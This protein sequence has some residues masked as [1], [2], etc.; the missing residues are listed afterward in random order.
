MARFLP[1][2]IAI[3]PTFAIPAICCLI[4]FVLLD[5]AIDHK[6]YLFIFSLAVLL[7]LQVRNYD[8]SFRIKVP[9][10][11]SQRTVDYA[12]VIF[13]SVTFISNYFGNPIQSVA[14]VS[15]FITIL[16]VP[17]WVLLR[18]VGISDKFKKKGP[19]LV[20]SFTISIALNGIILTLISFYQILFSPL[21]IS[22]YILGYFFN[23]NLQTTFHS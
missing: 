17:G 6:M 23:P 4:L 22:G 18:I 21:C 1:N 3:A 14:I 13:S 11:L 9:R 2:F 19:T 10:S 16:F 15:S 8:F 7:I 5:G 20:L 12:I